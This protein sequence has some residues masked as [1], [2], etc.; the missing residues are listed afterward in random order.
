MTK[1]NAEIMVAFLDLT[2][3][4]PVYSEAC[5]SLKIRE[6]TL[7][8]WLAQ[9]KR[10]AKER[11]GE[12]SEFVISYGD[13]TGYFHRFAR[14]A[15]SW[16]ISAIEQAAR[17]RSLHGTMHPVRFQGRT[18]FQRDRRLIGLP[19]DILELCGYPDDLLRD[20]N[21]LP[22][23]E[24]EWR[25]PSTDLTLALLSAYSSRF[26]KSSSVNVSVENRHSGGVQVFGSPAPKAIQQAPLPM[27]QLIEGELEPEKPLTDNEHEQHEAETSE[28]TNLERQ[29]DAQR[30]TPEPSP[31]RSGGSKPEPVAPSRPPSAHGPLSDLQ[32]DLLARLAAKPGAPERVAPVPRVPSRDSDDTNPDRTGPGSIPLGGVR[33]A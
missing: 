22:I 19:P 6:S 8:R 23:P 15:I 26:K 14:E 1:R 27:L 10:D 30:K 3:Q 17:H 28:K 11:P 21:G 32:R 9:S 16:S 24:M 25:P 7:Y 31:E 20:E 13:E 29:L 18:I 4:S 12:P 5:R 33:M 2:S